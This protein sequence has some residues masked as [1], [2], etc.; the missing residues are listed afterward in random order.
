MGKHSKI[1]WTDHTW[2]PWQGCKKVSAGCENCYMFREKK[3]YGQNPDIVIRSKPATFR[4]PLNWKDPAKIFVC[5]W[6]DFFIEEADDW[7]PEAW[8]I[9]GHAQEHTFLLLTKRPENIA[10]RLPVGWIEGMHKYFPNVWIGVTAENQKMA[11]LRIPILLDI[12]AQVRFVSCEPLLGPIVFDSWTDGP[13]YSRT[14]KLDWVIVGGESGKNCREMRPEWA[15]SI[16]DQCA[17]AEVPFFMK[18]MTGN[19][20]KTREMIPS[21][22]MIREFPDG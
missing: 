22:L 9:M 2:N 6:S 3:R 12:P 15:R 14:E 1:E 5:S 21:D 16:R 18:Q 7:R 19:T 13:C 8:E 20:K 4:K 10:S 17:F 11:D